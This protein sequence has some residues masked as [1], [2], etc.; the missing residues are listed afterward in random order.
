MAAAA[1]IRRN[2]P[3]STEH[4][5]PQTLVVIRFE[6]QILVLVA[7]KIG[8]EFDRAGVRIDQAESESWRQYGI[9]KG[10]RLRHQKSAFDRVIAIERVFER[11]DFLADDHL[12][13]AGSLGENFTDEYVVT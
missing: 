5:R 3:S 1:I 12:V 13:F 8:M 7:A 11:F 4:G 10:S 9:E 6:K 2:H